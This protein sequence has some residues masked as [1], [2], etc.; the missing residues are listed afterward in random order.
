MDGGF[1]LDSSW[2]S[3]GCCHIYY[4]FWYLLTTSSYIWLYFCSFLILQ[5]CCIT[6]SF[7]LSFHRWAFLPGRC[8][9]LAGGGLT[10]FLGPVSP[11]ACDQTCPLRSAFPSFS[12]ARCPPCHPK[13]ELLAGT[14]TARWESIGWKPQEAKRC[15]QN[16]QEALH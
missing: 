12:K 9:A 10:A 7:W 15:E 2:F 11:S 4:I 1:F 8:G 3:W 14:K 13:Y 5:L 16:L 6:G